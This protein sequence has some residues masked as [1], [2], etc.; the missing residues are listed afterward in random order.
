MTFD[1]FRVI[2]YYIL[3]IREFRAIFTI[4]W[5]CGAHLGTIMRFL[6]SHKG[7][8]KFN[9][10]YSLITFEVQLALHNKI[11]ILLCIEV[12]KYEFIIFTK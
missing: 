8:N 11:Y 1:L 9:I 12:F 4:G 5:A 10:F 3:I 2:Y 6:S 7:D